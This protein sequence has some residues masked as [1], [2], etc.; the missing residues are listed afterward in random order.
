MSND[1]MWQMKEQQKV[2][3]ENEKIQYQAALAKY[4]SDM[5]LYQEN[6]RE[7]NSLSVEEKNRRNR[8]AERMNLRIW[9]IVPA[10]AGTYV[11]YRLFI[12]EYNGDSV[13]IY[14]GCVFA[15]LILLLIPFAKIIG[16]LIRGTTIGAIAGAIC[17]IVISFLTKDNANPPSEHLRLVVSIVLAAICFAAEWFGAYRA[18]GAPRKPFGPP[19][20]PTRRA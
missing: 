4:N 1:L 8:E 3:Y 19:S 5:M 2:Q 10:C 11:A 16:R 6:L 15:F 12:K 13:W 9:T 18:S 20:P 17:Y 14:T 7:W